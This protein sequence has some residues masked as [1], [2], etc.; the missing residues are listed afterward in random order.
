MTW[1]SAPTSRRSAGE[2]TGVGLGFDRGLAARMAMPS[3]EPG[4]ARHVEAYG[5]LGQHY[6]ASRHRVWRHGRMRRGGPCGNGGSAPQSRRVSSRAPAP[7]PPRRYLPAPTQRQTLLFSATVPPGVQ[8]VA[9]MLMGGRDPTVIN[10]VKEDDGPGHKAIK[11]ARGLK[12]GALWRLGARL[13]CGGA[14]TCGFKPGPQLGAPPQCWTQHHAKRTQKRA[15]K[16]AKTP[17]SKPSPRP[18]THPPNQPTNQS[19]NRNHSP[20]HPPNRNHPPTHPTA[21]TPRST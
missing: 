9:R 8:D 1:G 17:Q 19:T 5:R 13:G 16:R 7:R 4:T 21:T 2:T 3:Y 14:W 10:C 11:Q 15:R 18:P 20:T 12:G 6:S